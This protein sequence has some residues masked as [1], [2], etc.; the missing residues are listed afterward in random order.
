ME[1]KVELQFNR[2]SISKSDFAEAREYLEELNDN[3]S[4]IVQRGLI[5]AAIVAYSR[6]FTKNR[7]GK[8]QKATN[9]LQ[10]SM[11]KILNQK[12]KELHRKILTLRHEGIAHSDFDR[13][14]TS[15]VP[16]EGSGVLIRSKPF[17]LLSEGIDISMFKAMAESMESYCVTRLIE[18]NRSIA[19]NMRKLGA[20]QRHILK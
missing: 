15:R 4:T 20:G 12:E 7:P 5:T 17:D 13:K 14:P 10:S 6:P 18:L 11:T 16:F 1:E 2:V 9:T 3:L 19:S 8:E